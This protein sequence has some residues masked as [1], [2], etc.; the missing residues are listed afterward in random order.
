MHVPISLLSFALLF[1][2]KVE[3]VKSDPIPYACILRMHGLEVTKAD[4]E[5]S[6]RQ[7]ALE[8]SQVSE[9]AQTQ[10]QPQ[11]LEPAPTQ[12]RPQKRQRTDCHRPA[13]G[14]SK[15]PQSRRQEQTSQQQTEDPNSRSRG[16]ASSSWM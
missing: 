16:V 1:V 15:Q 9:P 10:S 12:S 11:V 6:D 7:Y 3:A 4:Q 13:D 5:Y 8:K 2:F 14:G